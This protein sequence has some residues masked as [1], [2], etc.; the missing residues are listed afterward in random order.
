[1]N[2]FQYKTTKDDDLPDLGVL[3]N[4]EL[5][6]RSSKVALNMGLA[7]LLVTV[8]TDLRTQYPLPAFLAGGFLLGLGIYRIRLTRQVKSAARDNPE[9]WF[10]RF[11]TVVLLSGLVIGISIPPTFFSLESHWTFVICLMTI[12]G[13]AAG[14]TGSLSPSLGLMRTF[15]TLVELPAVVTLLFFGTGPEK[16]LGLLTL[17]FLGHTLAMGKNFHDLFRSGLKNAHLLKERASELEKAKTQVETANRSKSEFLNSMSQEIRIPL[18]VI[19]GLTDLALECEQGPK[20]SEYLNE[21]HEASQTLL[22]IINKVLD[23][24]KIEA[25]RMVLCSNEFSLPEVL[26]KVVAKAQ[27]RSREFGNTLKLELAADFPHL[28]KGDSERIGQ[29]IEHLLNNAIQFTTKGHITVSGTLRDRIGGF[30]AFTISVK[31]TGVGISSEDQE[32]IFQPLN[33]VRHS[34]P[35]NLTKNGLGLAITSHLVEI[36]GGGIT[37]NSAPGEGSEFSVHLTLPEAEPVVHKPIA[38]SPDPVSPD[39]CEKLQGIRVLLA[40]DN[41]VN[42]KLV[43]RLLEKTGIHVCWTKN[44]QEAIAQFVRED[45]DL[46]LM[47]IQMPVLDGF[48][49]TKAIREEEQKDGRHI[50]IVALTAF[51]FEGY[52]EKC[53]AAGMDDY[54]TKPLQPKVLRETLAKWITA[55]ASSPA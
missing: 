5:A 40:E 54:L 48:S 35:G 30:T 37:L 39:A 51:A 32:N 4:Q 3:I 15:V 41:T 18:N 17:A 12:T 10:R 42:A 31:D 7:I 6:S 55:S 53:L 27:T 22:G 45:F 52:R 38:T 9:S 49:A 36:M 25:G 33:S 20:Q 13:I 8:I 43:I 26:E 21:V 1:L 28:V 11:A 34:K 46:V 50:P 44:G 19:M 24:A 2:L 29:I 23:F 47:D 14:A 16:G